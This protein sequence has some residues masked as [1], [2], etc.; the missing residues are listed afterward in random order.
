MSSA[1]ALEI[2]MIILDQQ[3]WGTALSGCIAAV[4]SRYTCDPAC[5]V[6]LA[7]VYDQD[8]TETMS[9]TSAVFW[10]ASSSSDPGAISTWQ[11]RHH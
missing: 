11:P 1:I 8:F 10:I 2:E 4:A 9:Y 3:Q 7:F 5:L 6:S